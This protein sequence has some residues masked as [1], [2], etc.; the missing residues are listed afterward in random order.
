MCDIDANIEGSGPGA[1]ARVKV[2]CS[3]SCMERIGLC[4]E[5]VSGCDVRMSLRLRFSVKVK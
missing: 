3:I 1:W 4:L 2:L 5:L